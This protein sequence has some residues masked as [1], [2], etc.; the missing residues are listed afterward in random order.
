MV[1]RSPSG[2]TDILVLMV[3]LLDED[4]DRVTLDYGCGQSRHLIRMVDIDMSHGRKKGLIGVHAFTGCDYNSSFF[5]RGKEKCWKTMTKFSKF[6]SAFEN[7]GSMSMLSDEEFCTFEEFVCNLYGSKESG[8]DL[9]RYQIFMK[10]YATQKKVVDLSS[11]PTCKQVLQLHAAR[12]NT[13][14]AIW[15]SSVIPLID[16]SEIDKCWLEFRSVDLMGRK[17]IP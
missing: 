11:L 5:R 16:V 6:E 13:I 4:R 12:A 17:G 10:K 1:S 9:V 14:A 15:K 7:L 8:V 3:S 2:D